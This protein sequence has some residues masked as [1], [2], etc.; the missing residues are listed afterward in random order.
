MRT[1]VTIFVIGLFVLS[2][3]AVFAADPAITNKELAD[4][5]VRMTAAELPAGTEGLSEDEYYEVLANVLAARG[6]TTFLNTSAGDEV[7][8]ED[9][10]KILYKMVGGT[11]GATAE[12]KFQYLVDTCEMPQGDVGEKITAAQAVS[13]LNNPACAT[14]VAEAYRSPEIGRRDATAPG[15]KL[16]ETEPGEVSPGAAT[17]I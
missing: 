3:S 16:E 7:T 14:L 5:L 10:V 13:I 8:W 9:F 1:F 4:I 2:C 17:S 6:I 12:E 15:F 11:E